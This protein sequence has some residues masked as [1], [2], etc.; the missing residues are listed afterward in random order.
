MYPGSFLEQWCFV[1]KDCSY[2]LPNVYSKNPLKG[3]KVKACSINAGQRRFAMLSFKET[4]K[5]AKSLKIDLGTLVAWSYPTYVWPM[6]VGSYFG[7][8]AD[9]WNEDDAYES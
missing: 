4:K 3:A 6:F 1:P 7:L 9:D 2:G 8:I 5:L